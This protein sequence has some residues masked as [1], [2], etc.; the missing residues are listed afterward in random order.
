MTTRITER[1]KQTHVTLISALD[2]EYEKQG[3]YVKADHIGHPHGCPPKVN[4][5]IPDLAAY[6]NNKLC[7]ITEAETC[8]SISGRDT[9]EQWEAFSQSSYLFHVIVPKSCLTE[10]QQQAHIWGIKVDKWWWL[11]E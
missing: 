8:D 1:S 9:H 3:Y 7:I 4:G 10:A 6:S 11:G 5:H 2:R